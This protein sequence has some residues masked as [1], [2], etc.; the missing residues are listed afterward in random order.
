MLA[1]HRI[2]VY[3]TSSVCVPTV[4][5]SPLAMYV[6]HFS[7]CFSHSSKENESD[8]DDEPLCAE[9]GG[10]NSAVG[11]EFLQPGTRSYVWTFLNCVFVVLHLSESAA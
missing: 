10:D 7:T 5:F 8:D 11:L 6:E 4:P 2:H 1:I 3:T 9:Q